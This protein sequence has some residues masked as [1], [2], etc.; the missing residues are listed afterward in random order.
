MRWNARNVQRYSDLGYKY[1]R[2]GNVFS[3]A[4]SDLPEVSQALVHVRCDYCDKEYT[5]KWAVYRKGLISGVNKDCCNRHMC[6][7][8]KSADVMYLKHGVRC[9]A[10]M[11]S[12]IDKRK[13]TGLKKYRTEDPFANQRIKAKISATNMKRYGVKCYQQNKTVISKTEDMCMKRYGIKNCVELLNLFLEDEKVCWTYGKTN[14]KNIEI[15]SSI[16]NKI[17]RFRRL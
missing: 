16:G 11:Q 15:R 13:E 3:I 4:V 10:Y 1:T 9:S 5:T 12:T 7:G 6:T 17:V 2:I 14:Y 8:A